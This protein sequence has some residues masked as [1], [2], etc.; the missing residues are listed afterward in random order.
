MT[1]LDLANLIQ[2]REHAIA[3]RSF[4]RKLGID[5]PF[6][7]YAFDAGECISNERSVLTRLIQVI[8]GTLMVVAATTTAVTAGQMIV[9][10]ADTP[11]M[12]RA[13]ER[14]RFIQIETK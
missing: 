6:V 9:I 5:L 11:H 13:D 14:C 1:V 7:A 8:D 3:S 4:G 2:Y 10:P 12:L